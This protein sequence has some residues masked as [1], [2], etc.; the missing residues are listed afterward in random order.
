M[1]VI[2]FLKSLPY[3]EPEA[4]YLNAPNCYPYLNSLAKDLKAT[5]VLE[6]GVRF[7]YS[8]VAFIYGNPITEY[9]GID[10]DLY[11]PTS[12]N[13]SLEN[14]DYLKLTQPVNFTLFKKN[15]QELDDLAFLGSKTFDF[16]HVDGDH[17]FEG[18]L[19]DLKNFWNVLA[20]G[21]HMLVDDSTFY[22]SVHSA[23]IE[24]EKLIE[25]PSYDVKT[26]RGTWVFLKTK[27]RSFPITKSV[28][29]E[30]T[31]SKPVNEEDVVKRFRATHTG[32]SG[33]V[34]LL[35]DGTFRGGLNSPHG[36]WT[37]DGDVLT[38]KWYH[39][40]ETTLKSNSSG[41]YFSLNTCDNLSLRE[42]DLE[43]T[44]A[45]GSLKNSEKQEQQHDH[46][47]LNN[48]MMPVGQIDDNAVLKRFIAMH[49]GWSGILVLLKDGT[50]RGGLHNPDGRWMVDGGVL[51]LKW[52]HWPESQLKSDGSCGYVSL[53]PDDELSLQEY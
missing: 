45:R 5:R 1:S 11:D 15:T 25:E 13:K 31:P 50:F 52:Y 49:V 29:N 46:D 35:K 20:L 9:V 4:D 32:W 18:A 14:L 3:V 38:L 34:I 47:P 8:A 30:R 53:K 19:T 48:E 37:L 27:E 40:P 21:G 10:Y 43:E 23:C 24:F 33:M 36:R 12:S 16:I 42:G 44:D 51:T 7:G 26:Y 28:V 39:W 22:G 17:S 6:V 41:T 2:N